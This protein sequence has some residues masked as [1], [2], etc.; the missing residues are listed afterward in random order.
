MPARTELQVGIGVL[1]L[2]PIYG[3]SDASTLSWCQL[4]LCILAAFVYG[5]MPARTE[6]H[7]LRNDFKNSG[8]ISDKT[9]NEDVRHFS[10]VVSNWD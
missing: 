8:K 7:F 9:C 5:L 1:F 2:H 3:K 6:I 4:G 10:K